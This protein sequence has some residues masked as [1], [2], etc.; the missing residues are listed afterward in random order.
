MILND[1]NLRVGT[2]LFLADALLK[3]YLDLRVMVQN[4]L[5]VSLINKINNPVME[6]LTARGLCA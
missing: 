1:S 2:K 6:Y 3:V 4:S 5:R